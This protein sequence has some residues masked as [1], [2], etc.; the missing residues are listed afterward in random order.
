MQDGIDVNGYKATLRNIGGQ[1]VLTWSEGEV[2]F[3]LSSYQEGLSVDDLVAFAR[4]LK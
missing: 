4:S 3:Q 1:L 2:E